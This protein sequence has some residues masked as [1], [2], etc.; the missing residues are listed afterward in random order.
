MAKKTPAPEFKMPELK[1]PKFDLDALFCVTKA[2]L[3]VAHE[4]QT[5][6]ADAAEAITRLQYGYAE[7]LLAGAK[8]AL[9][10]KEP[11]EPQAA[12]A[13]VQ[14]AAGKAVEVTKQGVDLSVAAQ[15]KVVELVSQRVKA[16]V[17]ELKALA[18]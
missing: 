9:G 5:V 13:E 3:A 1:L 2:N 18:A 14:A 8:A 16:N 15:Q 11:K 7:E 10:A 17:D 12:L 6:L 4:A